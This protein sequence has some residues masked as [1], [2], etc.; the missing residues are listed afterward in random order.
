MGLGGQSLGAVSFW[1]RAV[2]SDWNEHAG[3]ERLRE[4]THAL[5]LHLPVCP[6]TLGQTGI[7]LSLDPLPLP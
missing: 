7:P 1:R 4:S 2:G 6:A 3:K 5:S